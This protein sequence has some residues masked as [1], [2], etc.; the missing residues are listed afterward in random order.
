MTPGELL[1]GGAG[2]DATI[3]LGARIGGLVLIAPVFA[4]RTI[5]VT[6]RVMALLV[7]TL[8]LAPTAEATAAGTELVPATLL[9]ETVVGFAIG[10]SAALFVGA[11][12]TAGEFMSVQMGLA[13]SRTLDPTSGTTA[14]TLGQLL[15]FLAVLLLLTV[16]GHL[17]MLEALSASLEAVPIGGAVDLRAGVA[18]LAALGARLFSLGMRFAAPV[19]AV[20]LVGY[21]ALGVVARAVPQM[22]VLLVAFPIQIGA[23]LLSLALVLP[24]VAEGFAS[25]PV[26]FEA[27]MSGVF[28]ALHPAGAGG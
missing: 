5:P 18:E 15:S 25:W 17:V 14:P 22:N 26:D 7:F 9:A 8:A 23:G 20:L 16:D 6:V 4:S 28:G 27:L 19:V 12:Q 3:L 13:G 2:V 10:F 21:V 24:L 1:P 11:A